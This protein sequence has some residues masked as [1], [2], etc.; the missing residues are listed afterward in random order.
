MKEA[1]SER[2]HQSE[3]ALKA[4]LRDKESA[5]QDSTAELEKVKQKLVQKEKESETL[6]RTGKDLERLTS[7]LKDDIESFKE[8]N[9]ML[10]TQL[11]SKEVM[12]A[13]SHL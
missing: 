9:S 10:E 4:A 3:L 6:G 5:L 13:Q 8:K 1:D 12:L 7:N 11:K 2:Y